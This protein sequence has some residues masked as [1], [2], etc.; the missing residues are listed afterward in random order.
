[1]QSACLR[2]N[3]YCDM[4]NNVYSSVAKNDG[5]AKLPDVTVFG[6]RSHE[7]I[8]DNLISNE[9]S[10]CVRAVGTFPCCVPAAET[11]HHTAL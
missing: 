9:A 3:I 2:V 11:R 5:E 7:Y 8:H 10:L 1:M 6:G 4:Q